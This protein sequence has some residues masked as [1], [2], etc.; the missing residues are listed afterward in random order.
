M[1]AA[2][3]RRQD[4]EMGDFDVELV[5]LIAAIYDAVLEPGRWEETLDR[6][7]QHFGFYSGILGVTRFG[8]EPSAFNISVNVPPEYLALVTPEYNEEVLRMWGG[9]EQLARYPLEEPMALLEVSGSEMLAGNKYARDFA[10]PQGLIDEVGIALTRDRRQIGHVGFGRHRDRGPV[11]PDILAGM[12]VLAPHLRRAALITGILEE[13]RRHVSM[14]EMVLEAVRSGVVLVDRRARIIYANPVAR[15]VMEMGEPIRNDRGTLEL[16]G[17]VVPG[18]LAAAIMAAAEGDMPLGRRGI[19]IPGMRADGSPFVAH[20]LPV[21]GRGVRSGMPDKAVAAVFVADRDEEPRLV[22]D[23]A[24]MIYSLTPAE[25]RVFELV[26]A[27]QESGAIAR[28]LGISPNTL[29]WH[30]AQLFGKTGSHRKADL[31]R[32]AGRLRLP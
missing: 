18:H 27:G 13:E 24:T 17:E 20:V 29:K 6:I 23:A 11:T 8:H 15:S 2:V 31:V 12:R 19:A 30:T 4:G 16:R 28:A 22:I 1:L 25:A 9:R 10:E 26:V 5:L 32:L 21:A 3:R 7:C 14:L